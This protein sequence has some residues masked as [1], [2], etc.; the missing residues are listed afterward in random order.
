MLTESATRRSPTT[1]ERSGL[2]FESFVAYVG[3]SC[4]FIFSVSASIMSLSHSISPSAATSRMTL[5]AMRVLVRDSRLMN[6]RIA[7]TGLS[8]RGSLDFDRQ[9]SSAGP[10]PH[11][12]HERED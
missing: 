3:R 1:L 9:P 12:G 11:G 5:S 7:T 4:L 2:S 10:Q 6:L 8:V